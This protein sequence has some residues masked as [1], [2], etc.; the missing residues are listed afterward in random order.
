MTKNNTP[1]QLPEKTFDFD[2]LYVTYPNKEGKKVGMEKL[3][4]I[5][6]TEKDYENFRLALANYLELCRIRG[7]I[8]G[9]FVKMWSTFVNNYEDYIDPSIVPSEPKSKN[10]SQLERIAKGQL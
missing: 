2:A 1:K 10:I 8:D 4:K 7:R 9:G 5:I 6:I 3:R